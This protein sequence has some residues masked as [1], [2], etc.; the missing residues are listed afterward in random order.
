MV[1]EVDRLVGIKVSQEFLEILYNHEG[2]IISLEEPVVLLPV[3]LV[4]VIKP[5]LGFPPEVLPP[6]ADVES[7]STQVLVLLG[8][9]EDELVTVGAP[10]VLYVHSLRNGSVILYLQGVQ[11]K[12]E[13]EN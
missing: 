5:S 4:A 13:K 10:G 3:V 2:V 8:A 6:L 12:R 1:S 9:H 7:H 11:K